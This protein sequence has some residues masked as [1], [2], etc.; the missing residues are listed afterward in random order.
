MAAAR[1]LAPG[2]LSSEVAPMGGP[3]APMG[4]PGALSPEP[5]GQSGQWKRHGR[6]IVLYGL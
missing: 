6:H 3:G 4:G 5:Q 1:R 2:L